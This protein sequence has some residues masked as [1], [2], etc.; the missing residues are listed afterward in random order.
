MRCDRVW[1]TVKDSRVIF[2]PQQP[3]VFLNYST[4][5]PKLIT[6][7][8]HQ[9]ASFLSPLPSLKIDRFFFSVK[10][11]FIFDRVNF[12]VDSFFG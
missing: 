11:H 7:V 9:E 10:F 6:S 8:G 12:F 4:S 3:V 5:I 1:L 2:G